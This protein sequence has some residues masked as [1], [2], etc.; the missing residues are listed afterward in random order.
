MT[1]P[2]VIEAYFAADDQAQSDSL[3][4]LFA[5]NAMVSDEHNSHKGIDAIT[6][7]WAAAKAQY[8]HKSEPLEATQADGRHIVRARVTGR[9]PSSPITLTYRFHLDAGKIVT[10][11]IG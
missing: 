4:T 10:L 8:E 1:I 11:E 5:S 6:A 7:W 3:K 9:F 2:A